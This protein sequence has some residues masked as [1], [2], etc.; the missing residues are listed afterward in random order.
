MPASSSVNCGKHHATLPALRSSGFRQRFLQ[1]FQCYPPSGRVG[2]CSGEGSLSFA[3]EDTESTERKSALD[4]GGFEIVLVLSETVLVLVIG[5]VGW[6][7][8]A[9]LS[10]EQGGIR[11][12]RGASWSRLQS[13]S[14][15]STV[16]LSTSTIKTL[17]QHRTTA[18]SGG[19]R[20]CKPCHAPES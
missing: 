7:N 9:L 17:G 11:G 20:S 10:L 15:T 16:S 12:G 4:F 13:H 8:V 6:A 14:S 18:E 5:P 19:W 1:G 3:T 2:A